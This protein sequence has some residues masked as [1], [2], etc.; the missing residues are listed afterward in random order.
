LIDPCT[1][2]DCGTNG[3]CDKGA[4]NCATG[5]EKD[6]N[7]KCNILTKEKFYGDYNGEDFDAKGVSVTKYSSNIASVA[8]D[9]TK[10]TI[11]NLGNYECKNTTTGGAL[12][13]TVDAKVKGDSISIDYKT[14][15]NLFV[16]KGYYDK[17]AKVL[18]INYTATY[19][20]PAKTDINK[21]V[22]KKK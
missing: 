9:V 5:Y 11:K 18:T 4:C 16:G 14:C 7:G 8:S 17:A 1:G 12:D 19:G 2:V 3:T 22:L 13:Y 15:N 21:A 20:T 6:L 10:I